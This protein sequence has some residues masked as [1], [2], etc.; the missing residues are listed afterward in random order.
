MV[1]PVRPLD[2]ETKDKCEVCRAEQA[3]EEVQESEGRLRPAATP[4]TK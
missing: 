1:M 4:L 3:S 2:L